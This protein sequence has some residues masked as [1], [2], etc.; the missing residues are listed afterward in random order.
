MKK[1][2]LLLVVLSFF[3][4]ISLSSCNQTAKEADTTEEAAPA[5]EAVTEEAV[6]AEDAATEEA[7]AEAPAEQAAE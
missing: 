5:E 3:A 1:I 7:P 4:F 2:S 6:P